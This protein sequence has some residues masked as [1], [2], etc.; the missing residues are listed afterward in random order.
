MDAGKQLVRSSFARVFSTVSKIGVAFFIMPFLIGELGDRWYGIWSIIAGFATYY[1]L[2]DFGLSSATSRFGAAAL[3]ENDFG[4]LNRV[5]S[6]AF[7]LFV[8]LGIVVVVVSIILAW[9][10]RFF[11]SDPDEL[12][13]IRTII[14]I[15]GLGLGIGFSSKAFGGV[16]IIHYRY[17]LLEINA[18][19]RLALETSAIFYFLS[20]GYGVLALALIFF[21]SITLHSFTDYLIARYLYRDMRLSS[22]DVSP[23]LA[24]EFLG[25][26]VWSFIMS[27]S[28]S[29][30]L[31]VDALVIGAFA[32][33]AMVTHYNVGAR[34]AMYTL[35]LL[36][37]ATNMITPLYTRLHTLQEQDSLRDKFLFFT[38]V[39]SMLG[40]FGGGLLIVIGHAFIERWMGPEY[41]DGYPVLV[42]LAVAVMAESINQP[43]TN[44][45]VA[46]A[47]HKFYALASLAEGV[48]NVLLSIVL[49]QK[50]GIV[51]VALGTAIPM[52]VV[53]LLIVPIYTCRKIGLSVVRYYLSIGPIIAVIFVYLGL[54]YWYG[55]SWLSVPDYGR[56]VTAMVSISLIYVV[57]VPFVALTKSEL[58]SLSRGIS[59]AMG[60]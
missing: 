49:L 58:R 1:Y 38:K 26:S 47:K 43:T 31:Q 24:R 5:I 37:R 56:V 25:F 32:S 52:L 59:A 19:I 46:I 28:D 45:L 8:F 30:R 53:R 60:R 57:F 13:L 29:L 44:V 2:L 40:V 7:S 10:A 15:Q 21:V 20:R 11:L 27:I 4:R 35:T 23:K 54:W 39:N 17:D 55:A 34:L 50:Y 51:G 6:T 16:A 18:L 48:V 9:A 14:L 12:T 36:N 3:A 41:L 22:G 42:V 33:A